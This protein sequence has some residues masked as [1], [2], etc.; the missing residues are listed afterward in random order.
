LIMQEPLSMKV[1]AKLR[2]LILGIG[3]PLRSDDGLGWIIAEQLSQVCITSYD[4]LAVHQLTPELAQWIAAASLIVIIDASSEGEPG[5][6]N[7]RHLSLLE[8]YSTLST[9]FTTPQELAMLTSVVY[10]QCPPVLLVTLTGADFSIGEKL[11]SIVA[12]KIPVIRETIRQ[13]CAAGYEL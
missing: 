7:I 2:P 8:N 12:E 5:E 6:I 9:H 11:S 13:L 4:V 10:G 3:N 1:S